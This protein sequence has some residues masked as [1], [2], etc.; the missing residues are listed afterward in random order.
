MTKI[1]VTKKQAEMIIASKVGD[2]IK[3]DSIN[4][5]KEVNVVRVNINGATTW[6]SDPIFTISNIGFVIISRSN[7]SMMAI[8][9]EE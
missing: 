5:I 9:I 2:Y 3:F 8:P 6:I 4:I 1:S 7:A